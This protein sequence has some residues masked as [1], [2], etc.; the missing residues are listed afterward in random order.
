MKRPVRGRR[1]RTR[2]SSKIVALKIV[3]KEVPCY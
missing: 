1:K 2:S 3:I